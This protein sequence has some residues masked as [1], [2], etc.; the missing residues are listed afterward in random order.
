[1]DGTEEPPAESNVMVYWLILQLAVIVVSDAG[2]LS[3]MVE[4]H[5]VNVYPVR[6]G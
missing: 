3:G 1:M 2:I 5:P 6:N 4:L